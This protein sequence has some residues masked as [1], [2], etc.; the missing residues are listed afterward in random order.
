[1]CVLQRKRDAAAARGGFLPLPFLP[2]P[3]SSTFF[4][5]SLSRSVACERRG[6]RVV[7]GERSRLHNNRFAALLV[8][9]AASVPFVLVGVCVCVGF[10][11]DT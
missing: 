2:L 3:S 8:V 7:R 11:Q 4:S 10:A 9:C 6:R 1:M 5:L